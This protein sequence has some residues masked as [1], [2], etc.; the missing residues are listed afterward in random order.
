MSG[1]RRLTDIKNAQSPGVGTHK[2]KS[3]EGTE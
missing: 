3:K 1:N 2:D